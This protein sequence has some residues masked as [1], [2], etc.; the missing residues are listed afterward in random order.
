MIKLTFI[1]PYYNGIKYIDENISSIYNQSFP[2]DEYEVAVYK[3]QDNKV[4][5]ELKNT[6][7][8]ASGSESLTYTPKNIEKNNTKDDEG[9][10]VVIPQTPGTIDI[11]WTYESA[12]GAVVT[13]SATDLDLKLAADNT[14]SWE[15][16]KH[17]IYTITL[18]A[19]EI[20]IAP[21]PIPWTDGTGGTV[22]VE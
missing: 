3:D 13:D 5:I 16:G 2:K 15:P 8:K 7:V 12:A 9:N 6:C 11:T 14:Q 4:G 17:Y 10:V 1:I 22:T 18:K 19:N 20:L 21:T